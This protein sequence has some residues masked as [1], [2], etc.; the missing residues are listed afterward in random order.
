MKAIKS[1]FLKFS[2]LIN[3]LTKLKY[4]DELYPLFLAVLTIV[5]WQFSN[6][7]GMIL[8]IFFAIFSIVFLNDLMYAVPPLS[9][10]IFNIKTGFKTDS[11]PVFLIVVVSIL[12]F[13]LLIQIIIN[14]IR[15]RKLKSAFGLILLSISNFIPIFW[16]SSFQNFL[17]LFYI[18]FFACFG[19]L[20]LYLF[21]VT[22]IKKANMRLLSTTFSYLILILF[23]EC[24]IMA[25]S[26]RQPGQ[27][28]FELWYYL[29][30]GLCNE[31]GIM[32]CFSVPFVYYLI[33]K[34]KSIPYMILSF[35]KLI[36]AC[37]TVLLTTSRGSYL[38][39]GIITLVSLF[40]TY[41]ICSRK[42]PYLIIVLSLI[43]FVIL[44]FLV[45]LPHSYN[46]LV[47]IINSVFDMSFDS[48]GRTGIW[49]QGIDIWKS[50][51]LYVIFGP[52]FASIIENRETANG[53]QN[54]PLVMHSTFFETLLVGGIIGLFSL[55]SH[56][57]QKYR[58]ILRTE[59]NI[60]FTVGISYFFIDLYGLIDNTY[61]MYYFMILLIVVIAVIDNKIYE[62]EKVI[63]LEGYKPKPIYE[64][65]KRTIDVIGSFIGLI[66]FSWLIILI[67]II[68]KCTSKGPVFFKDKRIGLGGKEVKIYK[69]RTMYVDAESR[70]K[71]YLTEEQLKQWQNE[72][73]IDN[74]PRITKVGKFLR[75][76]SLDELPQ[77]FNILIGNMSIWGNRP[78]TKMELD[79]WYTEEEKELLYTIK[80]GLTGYWQ[81]YGR[82]NVTFSSG[83][84][85]KLDLIYV[86]KRSTWLDIKIFFKTIIGVIFKKGA[87]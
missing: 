24:L 71:E 20:L 41:F 2:E 27:S 47:K 3:K 33:S 29:G 59:K 58:N 72:R 9:Y 56:L 48:N 12:I 86:S 4:F 65:L 52:G 70:L 78:I 37:I 53:F 79:K 50:N 75:K 13:A 49:Q 15:L 85:Q 35:F 26:I 43:G 81:A 39:Y 46:E 34:T 19:Y 16:A 21:L 45:T 28:Y 84:R 55:L 14:R 82:S 87:K 22:G 64:T 67:A 7:A 73:K 76:T 38:C 68:I 60:I 25:S 51:P 66:L 11:T 77:L 83:E 80:P 57:V 69:F 42:K 18:Y 54:V 31:A 36:V 40:V 62:A 44:I 63:V 5:G 30:W 6:D 10:F 32:V 8:L 23:A 74:D 61:F 17:P 1:Y